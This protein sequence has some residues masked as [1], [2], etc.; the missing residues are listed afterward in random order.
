MVSIIMAADSQNVLQLRQEHLHRPMC[1]NM[2]K[3]VWTVFMD[4]YWHKAL[5]FYSACMEHEC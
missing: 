4:F 1:L 3:Q 2:I 5:L